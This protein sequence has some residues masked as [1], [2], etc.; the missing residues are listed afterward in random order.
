[1]DD[2]KDKANK[3][4]KARFRQEVSRIGINAYITLITFGA[5]QKLMN[6]SNLGIM[7]TT[8][9][10]ALF[11]ESVSRLSNGKHITR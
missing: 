2:D 5:L 8:G 4:K 3:E 10:T 6:N 11:T 1:M 7:L 9:L